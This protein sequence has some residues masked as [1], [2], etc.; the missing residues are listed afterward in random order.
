MYKEIE[1]LMSDGTTKAVPMKATGS[2]CLRY[3]QFTGKE[4][5]KSLIRA[6][7]ALT[8]GFNTDETSS[9]ISEEADIDEFQRIISSLAF[10]MNKQ[11]VGDDMNRLSDVEYIN[12]LDEFD[13]GAF[14]QSSGEIMNLYMDNTLGTSVAK[15][16]PVRLTEK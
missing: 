9:E 8:T 5:M 11:G 10:I 14:I 2:T 3:K 13:S 7:N 16:N 1:M 6:M 15:K 12:W 4:I